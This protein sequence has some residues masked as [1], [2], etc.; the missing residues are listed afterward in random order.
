MTVEISSGTHNNGPNISKQGDRDEK[1]LLSLLIWLSLCARPLG[2]SAGLIYLFTVLSE[3]LLGWWFE[4]GFY[5]VGEGFQ[6][7]D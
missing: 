2:L 5:F 6:S 3:E 7:L 1:P 4:W